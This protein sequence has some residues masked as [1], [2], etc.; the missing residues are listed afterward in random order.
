MGVLYVMITLSC[1][2]ALPLYLIKP[3]KKREAT[4]EFLRVDYAHRGLYDNARG[5]PENSLVAFAAAVDKGYGIELDVQLT[6]DGQVVVFHDFDLKRACGLDGLV[7]DLTYHD[8]S[9]V[10]LFGSQEGIP[11]FSE[12]LELIAGRV[13]LIVEL[14]IEKKEVAPL[15]QAVRQHLANYS[16]AYCIESFNPL[17]VADF[18][19]IQ[20]Q[21]VR[22]QLS[23]NLYGRKGLPY[24]LLRN[25]WLNILSRPDFIAYELGY[26]QNVWLRLTKS[27]YQVPIIAFT[28]QSLEDYQSQKNFF[29]V[30][31]F[32][33]FEPPQRS[34]LPQKKP[35]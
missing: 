10:N 21:I 7:T 24:W 25:L 28:T 9:Q 30:Q 34:A 6:A 11:L 27:L 14:K 16:G 33:H 32:E 5:C 12:V 20:P 13:P 31:I 1:L 15:C 22:G 35:N 4:A 29:A 8:L 23:G 26:E 19:R 18:R 3:R 17:A 2:L